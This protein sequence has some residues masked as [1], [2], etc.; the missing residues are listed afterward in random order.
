MTFVEP[1]QGAMVDSIFVWLDGDEN[2][3]V[4]RHALAIKVDADAA[5]QERYDTEK[6]AFDDELA[7]F[8]RLA[9]IPHKTFEQEKQMLRLHADTKRVV[10]DFRRV[11]LVGFFSGDVFG[12]LR[13]LHGLTWCVAQATGRLD[14]QRIVEFLGAGRDT[15]K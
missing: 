14:E 3:H 10:R 4:V 9:S 1:A 2:A 7:E 11:K 15:H 8:N 5:A 13:Q 6:H 12:R